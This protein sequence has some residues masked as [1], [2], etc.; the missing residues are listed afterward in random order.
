MAH[1]EP[2][3]IGLRQCRAR[4][5][6]NLSVDVFMDGKLVSIV[7]ACTSLAELSIGTAASIAGQAR[8]DADVDVHLVGAASVATV[9]HAMPARVLGP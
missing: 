6:G 7:V 2:Q 8:D 1:A 9:I 4:P 3:A 5:G